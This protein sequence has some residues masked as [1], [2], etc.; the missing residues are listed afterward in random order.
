MGEVAPVRE[1]ETDAD[2]LFVRVEKALVPVAMT[3]RG[4][5][6]VPKVFCLTLSN[7]VWMPPQADCASG[8]G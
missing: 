4:T 8:K 5:G 1:L 2:H 6:V 3:A 7:V